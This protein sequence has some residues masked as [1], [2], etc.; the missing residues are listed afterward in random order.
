[1]HLGDI[2]MIEIGIDV[3]ESVSEG[4]ILG[5]IDSKSSNVL[6]DVIIRGLFEAIDF[7]LTQARQRSSFNI[8]KFLCQL[9]LT[10]LI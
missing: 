9:F 3:F 5:I 6:H 1:M 2:F 10:L 7:D 8:V 4:S